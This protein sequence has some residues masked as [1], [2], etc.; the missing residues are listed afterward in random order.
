M[1]QLQNQEMVRAMMK[2]AELE[3][4]SK[5]TDMVKSLEDPVQKQR[6]LVEQE[7]QKYLQDEEQIV[8]KLR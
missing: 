4:G 7:R 6:V 1:S 2:K 8:I 5:V 3:I